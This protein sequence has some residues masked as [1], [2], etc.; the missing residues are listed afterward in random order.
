MGKHMHLRWQVVLLI[1]LTCLPLYAQRPTPQRRATVQQKAQQEARD[2]EQRRRDEE[3]VRQMPDAGADLA[4]V[5]AEQ[6]DIHEEPDAASKVLLSVKRGEALALI[7]REPKDNWYKVIHV[8][9]ANEGWVEERG[10]IVKFTAKREN[11]PP[12]EQEYVGDARDP[13][14]SVTNLERATD[15]NLRLNGKRYV[16]RAGTTSTF[17]LKPGRYEFYGWSPGISPAIGADDLR[18]GVRYSWTFKIVMRK[19]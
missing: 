13:E 4:F 15:L 11:A 19:G 14:L 16:V 7:E 2:R 18:S 3:A 1:L 6:V 5:V 12:L 9:S 17:N 8:D 10:V